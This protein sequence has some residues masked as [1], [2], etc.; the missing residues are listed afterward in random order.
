MYRAVKLP[1]RIAGRL[2]LGSMPG[3]YEVFQHALQAIAE[4]GITRVVCLVPS[5]E[6]QDK[7]PLYAR[8]VREQ[9]VPWVHESFPI[10]DFEAPADREAFWAL[11]RKVA[12]L[13]A[14]GDTILV[15]CAAGIGRTGK[16]F[17]WQHEN[18]QPDVMALAKGLGS[19]VPIGAIVANERGDILEP[20]DHGTT[21]GGQPFTT[22]VALETLRVIIEED[23]PAQAAARGEQLT[24]GI[25]ALED[26]HLLIDHVRG[27][28][29]LVAVQLSEDVGPAL[30]AA[31]RERGLICNVVKPNVLRLVPP[32]TISEDEIN[33]AIGIIDDALASIAE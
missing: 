22:S 26:R 7:S 14:A 5:D 18:V 31:I 9:R 10:E 27:K 28:G 15:H 12:A 2:Y 3:R 1:D 30:V 6:L 21:F 24:S 23:I 16:L 13:L 32:L 19:G 33:D 8:A 25:R 11:T 4:H 17:A 29:L 20:G